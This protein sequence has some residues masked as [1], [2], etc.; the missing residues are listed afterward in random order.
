MWD[1]I[2]LIP[3]HFLSIYFGK[4]PLPFIQVR[5]CNFVLFQNLFVALS[6]I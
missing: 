4:H 6:H 5:L 1:V 3:D 2:L